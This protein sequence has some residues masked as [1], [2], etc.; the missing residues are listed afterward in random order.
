[1]KSGNAGEILFWESG[2]FV[3]GTLTGEKLE[4]DKK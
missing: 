2:E 3:R 1:M 4:L